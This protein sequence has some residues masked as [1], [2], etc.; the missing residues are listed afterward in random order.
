MISDTIH[1]V[2]GVSSSGK[3]TYIEHMIKFGGWKDIPLLMAYE[4]DNDSIC[5]SLKKEC[6]IH[7][8][9]FRPYC[10]DALNI[11]KDLLEDKSLSILLEY[12]DRI[13]ACLI[14]AHPAVISKRVLLRVDIEP[15][16]RKNRG[17]YPSQKIFELLCRINM[18]QFHEKWIDLLV[19]FQIDFKILNSEEDEFSQIESDDLRRIFFAKRNISYTSSEID[20]I[21]KNNIFEYQ[22]L[23][24]PSVHLETPVLAGAGRPNLSSFDVAG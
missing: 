18:N 6:I 11:D 14:V 4:V 19:D 15:S 16:L 5:E 7:Y 21:I 12:R 17:G 13:K 24:L 10:N 22:Q 8:N 23:K 1:L 20:K 3:S 2:L 9:L